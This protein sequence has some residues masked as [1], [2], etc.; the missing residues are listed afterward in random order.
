[1]HALPAGGAV[2]A[3]FQLDL[4]EVAPGLD[5]VVLASVHVGPVRGV[6]EGARLSV[7]GESGTEDLVL[8]AGTA[9]PEGLA[10]VPARAA[11]DLRA[12]ASGGPL[13]LRLELAGAAFAGP[14][15]VTLDV[16]V[17]RLVPHGVF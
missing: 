16:C 11:V 13:P 12:L 6:I 9:S 5:P 3:L 15:S 7:P 14:Q 4:G 1:V 10:L 17:T 2:G 8:A